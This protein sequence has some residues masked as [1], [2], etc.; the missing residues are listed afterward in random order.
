MQ[1]FRSDLMEQ[2]DVLKSEM[3]V[4]FFPTN[5]FSSFDILLHYDVRTHSLLGPLWSNDDCFLQFVDFANMTSNFSSSLSEALQQGGKL[6]YSDRDYQWGNIFAV[7]NSLSLSLFSF[8]ALLSLK[9]LSTGLI[10]SLDR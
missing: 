6:Y 9:R 1:E 4:G 8:L 10:S 7:D 2:V 3:L 5:V